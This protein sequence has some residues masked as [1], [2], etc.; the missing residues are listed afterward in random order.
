MQEKIKISHQRWMGQHGAIFL[1]NKIKS[2]RVWW[3]YLRPYEEEQ[4]KAKLEVMQWGHIL[5]DN[6]YSE[7]ISYAATPSNNYSRPCQDDHCLQ[8]PCRL[9]AKHI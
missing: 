4:K 8:K 5:P 7:Y 2:S 1:S 3:I 6:H 9:S